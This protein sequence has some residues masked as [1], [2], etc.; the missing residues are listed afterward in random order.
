MWKPVTKARGKAELKDDCT[1]LDADTADPSNRMSLA[2]ATGSWRDELM[3]STDVTAGP[4]T[5]DSKV[6]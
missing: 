2:A 1:F 6:N 3:A 4:R 5:K